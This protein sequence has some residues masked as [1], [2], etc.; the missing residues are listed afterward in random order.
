MGLRNY[1]AD[2][3]LIVDTYMNI[4]PAQLA[5]EL[6]RSIAPI[7]RVSGDEP[8]QVQECADKIRAVA[9]RAGYSDVQRIQI[10]SAT[11]WK[12]LAAVSSAMS[13]FGDK[14]LLDVRLP[15]GKPG[16]EGGAALVA[17]CADAGVDTVL[18]LQ[19][20]KFDA[21]TRK[22]KWSKTLDRTGTS[23]DVYPLNPR[24]LE[25]WVATKLKGAGYQ[26]E[27]GAVKVI[28]EYVEGNMLAASQEIEKLMLLCEPGD[29]SR[30]QVRDAITDSARYDPFDFVDTALKGDRVRLVR[31]LEGL[32]QEG[33]NE[34]QILWIM[35]DKLRKM[36]AVREA[37]DTGGNEQ[38]ALQGL[39]QSQ[40]ALVKQAA[41]RLTLEQCRQILADLSRLDWVA[42]GQA[43][44]DV[45]R[46]MLSLALRVAG[47][48]TIDSIDAVRLK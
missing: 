14:Q 15:N 39:W 6:K 8:F 24:E 36:V 45:W 3:E 32:Q 10:D 37:R 18:I 48:T 9:K 5:A 22:Q 26:P 7:Y 2:G 41:S 4:K 43:K 27:R 16:K 40:Q 28:C 20:G 30:Q 31:M 34:N 47:V 35:T 29:V 11:D 23:I 46:E 19:T 42:K 38:Q 21:G 17:Y 25:Q 12:N 13:L 1:L 33:V 44:G